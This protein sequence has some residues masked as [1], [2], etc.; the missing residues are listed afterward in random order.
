MLWFVIIQLTYLICI[1]IAFGGLTLAFA[2][3]VGTV[4]FLFLETVIYIKITG[5]LD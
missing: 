1:L 3:G 2:I 5:Y 4:S